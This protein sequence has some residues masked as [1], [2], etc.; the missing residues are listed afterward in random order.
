MADV[1]ELLSQSL[2]EPVEP[3]PVAAAAELEQATRHVE[4]ARAIIELDPNGAYHLAYDGARKAAV[5]HLRA[6]GLRV[7]PNLPGAHAVT[8]RYV[9]AAVDDSLG[10]R[11]DAMRRKR[12]R[13]EYEIAYI[14]AGE[15][16]QVILHAA[17]LV[18]EVT[19][20]L[21]DGS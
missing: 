21:G 4:A 13:S 10:R 6:A 1:N 17:A 20:L 18:A 7:P 12:N 16:G 15:V 11:L 9:R 14:E 8:A 19:R 5:A 2:L 3:D